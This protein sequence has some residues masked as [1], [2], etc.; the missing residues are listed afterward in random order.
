MIMYTEYAALGVAGVLAASFFF[1][2]C[3]A[4]RLARFNVVHMP[5][6][7]RGLP[8]PAGGLFLASIV[9]AGVP[10]HPLAAALPGNRRPHDLERSVRKP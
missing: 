2:L 10:L 7:F 1:A 9:L 6:P 5:G 4:L 3:G 8:I